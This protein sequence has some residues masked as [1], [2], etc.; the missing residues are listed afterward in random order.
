MDLTLTN[1]TKT[2]SLNSDGIYLQPELEGL[3]GLPNI[4]STSGV[5]AGSDGGWT[6]AQ[7]FDAR[8]IS[9]KCVI[10][11]Q[12]PATV[13]QKRRELMSLLALGKA[14]PLEIR[15]TTE[16][17]NAYTINARVTGVTAPLGQILKKQDVLIQLRADDPLIYAYNEE[18]GTVATLLVQQPSGGFEI[19]FTI[20]LTINGGEGY[21]SV[22][23]SGTEAVYPVIELTGPLHNPS[24]VNQT[25]NQIIELD[26]LTMS[27]SDK[28]VIDTQTRTVTLNGA[29]V[30]DLLSE[31]SSFMTILPG[32]N[33]M[34]LNSDT[35]SDAGTAKIKFK[36]GF[37]T[38]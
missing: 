34:A 37:I 32:E 19:P 15:F 24:V 14:N 33:I 35:T 13:E 5:N 25:G 1:G 9:I 8:L 18:G 36:Q 26:N 4:R 20:P 3:T 23:N 7:F 6:S 17:G 12:S 11:D 16:S 31:D 30:Y 10:A 27:A 38:I 22:V 29:D 2:I 28:V 21:T